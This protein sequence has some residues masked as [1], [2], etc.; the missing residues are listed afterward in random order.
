MGKGLISKNYIYPFILLS[1]GLLFAIRGVS[2]SAGATVKIPIYSIDR[3]ALNKLLIKGK[4]SKLAVCI[5]M[6]NA[7]FDLSKSSLKIYPFFKRTILLGSREYSVQAA[8]A[9]IAKLKVPFK[10]VCYN[11]FLIANLEI[12]ISDLISQ[13]PTDAAD[14]N[15]YFYPDILPKGSAYQLIFNLMY[16]K[17]AY[18]AEDL[19]TPD[20]LRDA[21]QMITTLNPSPP[22]KPADYHQ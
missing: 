22:S 11:P 3:A 9:D 6:E 8:T 2:Q 19:D 1:I 5:S 16:I 18:K 10:D 7:A 15:I 14:N 12:N 4:K 21:L 20:K 13:L 17:E